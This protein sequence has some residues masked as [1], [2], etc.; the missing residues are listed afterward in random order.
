[1]TASFTI[2]HY[3]ITSK[4]GEGAMGEVYR[5]TD[6]SLNREVAVKVLPSAL[7]ADPARM[8]R[9]EREAHLLASV[10]HP[11]IAA[12]YSVEQGAIVMEL[13]E[14]ADLKGPLPLDVAL[15]Y[16]AQIAA[17]L[18]AAHEKGIVHRDLKPSNIKVTGP[19]SGR[20]GVVKLLDFGL[21]KAAEDSAVMIPATSPTLSLEM[22]QAGTILGT[23]AYMAPE[24]ARGAAVDKRA[25]VWAFGVVLFEM[26]A[27]VTPFHGDTLADTLA[28]VLLAAIDWKLLPRGTPPAVCH[29]LARCLE[30]DPHR[31]LR[32]I[33][34]A[35]IVLSEPDAWASLPAQREADSGRRRRPALRALAF[36]VTAAVLAGGVWISARIGRSPP[37]QVTRLSIPM[38]PGQVLTGGGPAVSRDGRFIAYCARGTD[39]V[40]RLYMRALDRFESREVHGSEGAQLPFFSPDGGRIGFFAGG[41]LLTVVR[42]GGVPNA[43]ADASYLPLGATWGEDDVIFYVPTLAS[44]ILRIPAAGGKPQ[45][46]TS[47]DGGA[48][49][50]AH[51]WPQ[52]LFDTHSLLFTIWGGQ[53]VDALGAVLLSPRTA[54]RTRVASAFWSSRYAPP[55]YLL[56]SGSRGVMATGFDPGRPR[57]VRP[58]TFVVED[59][60][61]SHGVVNS[62]FAV[63]DTGTLV[64]VPG[65]PTLSTLAWVDRAGAVT[66]LEDKPQSMTDPALS[67]DGTQVVVSD[68]RGLWVRDLRRG[69]KT[70]LTFDNQGSNQNAIWSR[71]GARVIFASNR[72]NDWDLYS[73]SPNGGTATRLLARKG[74]QF[75]QSEAPDGTLLFSERSEKIGSDLWTLTPGGKVTP[76]AVSPASKVGAQFSPDGRM[77][78]YV[79]DETGRN[80][81]YLRAVAK[82]G[83]AL[84]GD[85]VMVSSD[86][87]SEPK[88]SPDGREIFYR[89]GDTFL[90]ANVNPAIGLAAGEARK[91]FEIRAAWGRNANHTGY[92]ISPDG[93]R[94]LVLR[95]DP[96]A[97]P[98]KID[99]VLN[100]FEE[101]K[102][103]VPSL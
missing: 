81:V 19:A 13:V 99:V 4:L 45:A 97:I 2:G 18:E 44:G 78:V 40:S 69:T 5:A 23:A 79:S 103:K 21:A 76:F 43:I 80:E 62:W 74:A 86:G 49:G 10:S 30:R 38:P 93:R 52:Y 33:G 91:L 1:M 95:L 6:T 92:A 85:A 15:E 12:I 87:G 100:W 61:F 77:V 89:R 67:P 16:A 47:P 64:Y 71:D 94:F 65:D 20:P 84:L 28:D 70:R 22:T 31:R 54:A 57:E 37:N 27:G 51:T 3:K 66:P 42:E 83:G 11:N 90:A 46:L 50:Y 102:A 36:G 75:P 39:G 98:T 59:V 82:P 41:K 8:A 56:V 34:E 60:F 26:L 35:R 7:A 55:G 9:F 101:L 24:Q 53:N 88:W 73:V 29:L 17:G 96:R 48:N 32:D 68:D 25:D 63:S 72:D 58:N 14:G